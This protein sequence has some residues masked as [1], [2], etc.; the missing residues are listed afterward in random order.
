MTLT[1]FAQNFEDVMLWRA[2]REV[3]KGQYL[4]IG[5]QDPVLDSVSLAFYQVG[6]R[7]IH[8]EASPHYSAKL[9][10]ARPD[11]MVIQAAVTDEAGPVKFYEIPDTGLSTGCCDVAMYHRRAGFQPQKIAVPTVRLD[12]LLEMFEGEIHWMKIDVEGMEQDVLRS[13]GACAKRP[14]ILVI[15]GTSPS[16]QAP[17]YDA[18]VFEVE[19][20]GYRKIFFDGLN[21]YFIHSEKA[22]LESHFRAPANV[23]D[24]FV[25]AS[26]H[27]SAMT[28]RDEIA[29]SRENLEAEHLGAERLKEELRIALE[30][31]DV[32]RGEKA[33]T[34]QRMV[35]LE[36]EHRAATEA[37]WEQRIAAEEVLRR[38]NRAREDGLLS[39]SRRREDELRS[40][41][42]RREEELRQR[43]AGLIHKASAAEARAAEQS[44]IVARSEERLAQLELALNQIKAETA[45]RLSEERLAT[46]KAQ[47]QRDQALAEVHA[48]LRANAD[49]E[50][51]RDHLKG[52]IAI[53]GHDI[54]Q[55]AGNESGGWSRLGRVF[56][57][58][59]AYS[60]W[61]A[62]GARYESLINSSQ[63]G[64]SNIG[65]HTE[66][67]SMGKQVTISGAGNPY[68]RAN[69]LT[70]LLAWNDLDFVRCAYVTILGRQP[71]PR[72][73]NYYV[74]RIRSGRSKEEV[75][76]QLR[77]STE[78]QSHDPGIAGLD[79][80]LKK[81]ARARRPFTGSIFRALFGGEDDQPLVRRIRR[82][83]NDFARASWQ[84]APTL[85]DAFSPSQPMT[86]PANDGA[87]PSQ[88]GRSC[89]NEPPVSFSGYQRRIFRQLGRP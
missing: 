85:T 77:R 72:G 5:A 78:G 3:E 1:S 41:S 18:W 28:L 69:S 88:L 52:A 76:W 6:W 54:Q 29:Q 75:L 65:V 24:R 36:Q 21:C 11:E 37:L 32:A 17:T 31:S 67:R 35:D 89:E 64:C 51:Q 83:E 43:E 9:R 53:L 87:D 26:H 4:D 73:E 49:L 71:D 45:D 20:R 48:G 47:G 10:D 8:V 19:K 70:E 44:G 34:L 39:E 60:Q 82:L 7:G 33:L 46:S 23:F 15:E 57:F 2:L 40:E 61:K 42:R 59:P 55:G 62:L 50:A 13:W 86:L 22:D 74:E 84:S 12:Q 14:W 56:G 79:R 80:A 58:T 16:T 81:A 68:L 25:V 63:S 38:D 30:Q 27:F 66:M